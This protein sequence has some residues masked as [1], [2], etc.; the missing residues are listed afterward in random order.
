MAK[1]SKPQQWTA[2]KAQLQ[3]L[4]K[5]A[6]VAL[7]GDLYRASPENRRFLHARVLGD[8]AEIDNYRK[9]VSDAVYPRLF[10]QRPVRVGEAKRLIRLTLTFIED[11]TKQAADRGYGADA[12]IAALERALD[13]VVEV[14][15]N[16]P[17]DPRGRAGAR[18]ERVAVEA[19]SIGWGYGDYV[20]D[21]AVS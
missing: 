3:R 7:V 14:L 17:P 8:G 2:V 18:I 1:D 21:V 12:Y 5:P 15:E 9:L 11:G 16:L 10:S 6:L 4:T 20:Q 13:S 19:A